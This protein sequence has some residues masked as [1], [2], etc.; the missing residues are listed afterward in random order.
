MSAKIIF[1]GEADF[2]ATVSKALAKSIRSTDRISASVKSKDDNLFIE[3]KAKNI[4]LLQSV[5]DTY[6]D[7]V[8]A[9]EEINDL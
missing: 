4:K 3:I 2:T 7:A 1:K 5:I 6:L 9:V 8:S